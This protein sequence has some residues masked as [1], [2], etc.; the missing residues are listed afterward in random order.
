MMNETIK[1]LMP[2]LEKIAD[3][4]ESSAT[5]LWQIQMAQAKVTALSYAI[6]WL[7]WI[8]AMFAMYKLWRKVYE[9]YEGKW[10]RQDKKFTWE[11]ESTGLFGFTVV[12]SLIAIVSFVFLPSI[13]TLI[14]L[15]INPEYWALIELLR[16]VK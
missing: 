4:L 3:K 7:A 6:E 8:I 12:S 2:Y 15:V 5:I 9:H 10:E 13:K 14:T 11:S 1:E 16:M